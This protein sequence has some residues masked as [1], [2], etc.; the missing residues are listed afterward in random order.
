MLSQ[1]QSSSKTAIEQT[2]R[3]M[4]LGCH[5]R[6]RHFSDMAVRLSNAVGSPED[7]I[8]RAAEGV[9]RYFT[10]A[11]PLHEADENQSLH[12]RMLRAAGLEVKGEE[13]GYRQLAGAAADAMVEQH[14][15]IDQ[16]VERLIPLW[17]VVIANPQ[18]L[19]ELSTE[20][21]Q[22][23]EA[24][25]DIFHS[26]LDLEEQTIFPAMEKLLSKSEAD[27]IFVEMKA[28]RS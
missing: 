9:N 23:S 20:L 4:L 28:R 27:A 15:A 11:L 8:R 5:A 7:E 6:I 2:A 12:P 3:E 24:L 17:Q 18:K 10:I 21:R 25:R 16:I 19:A 13:P 14:E 1:I 22:L 26:H